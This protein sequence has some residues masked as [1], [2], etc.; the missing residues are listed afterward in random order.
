MRKPSGTRMIVRRWIGFSDLSR[1]A[2]ALA[3]TGLGSKKARRCQAVIIFV[4]ET[5]SSFTS[6][7]GAIFE[8]YDLPELKMVDGTTEVAGNYPSKS[9]AGELAAWFRDS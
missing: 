6:A 5:G 1:S 8:E 4:G 3:T 2:T 9:G 7:R